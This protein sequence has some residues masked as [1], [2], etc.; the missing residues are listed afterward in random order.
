MKRTMW[1]LV[2]VAA[3]AAAQA[4]PYVVLKNQTKMVGAAIRASPNG[5]IKLTR[6]DGQ[7]IT[8]TKDQYLQAVTDKPATFDAAVAAVQQKSFDQ[9]IP[10]LEK[11]MLECRFLEWDKPAGL[12]LAKAYEGKNDYASAIKVYETLLKDYPALETDPEAGVGWAMRNAL[13]GSKQYSKLE[14]MLNTLIAGENRTEAARATLLRGDIRAEEN[15]PEA[16]IRDYLRTVLFY[17][18]EAAVMPQALL[19]T[20]L[21]LEK[22]RDPRAKDMF[23]RLVEEYPQ[24]PEAATAKS[25]LR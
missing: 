5:D 10:A 16:A 25:K 19:K 1:I 20:G 14:P 21:A 8:L 24:S 4:A 12:Q 11:I 23:K 3:A 22:L 15:K 2:L 17:E 13:L 6:T 7:Q 18:R 9:A